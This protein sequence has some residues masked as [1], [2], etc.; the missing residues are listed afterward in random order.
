MLIPS[1]LQIRLL[2][3]IILQFTLANDLVVADG[4]CD[5]GLQLS[6]LVNMEG[7][8]SWISLVTEFTLKSL[9][10]WQVIL[11]YNFLVDKKV[12]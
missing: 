10:S 6:E 4:S 1:E 11:C 7:Y 9:Q 8:S 3:Y 2:V 12:H 5:Y